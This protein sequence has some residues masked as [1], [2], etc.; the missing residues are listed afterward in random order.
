MTVLSDYIT[1]L[2]NLL[3]DPFNNFYTL[4]NMKAWINT[5]RKR[6]AAEAQAIR[7]LPT[8][9]GT[10]DSIAVDT[11]GSLYTTATV[12]IS[13]PDAFGVGFVTA[14]ATAT[15]LAGAV[16]AI[17]VTNPG[18]GYIATPTVTITGD[19]SGATATAT[20][21]DFLATVESQ[22]VYDFSTA[23]ALLIA[24]NPGI[25][26]IIAV[27]S[28]A[29]SWGAMKP[30]LEYRDWSS[31]Q[32]YLRSYNVGSQNYPTVW[33]QYGRG[34]SGSVYF[35]P[36]P[37]TVAGMDWDCYCDP[38]A[39]TDDDDTE[40]LPYPWTD[41]VQFLAAEYAYRNAQRASDAARMKGEYKRFLRENE[42][43]VQASMV[44]SFY[45]G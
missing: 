30:V 3:N 8:S 32:A 19:G 34:K 17:T 24:A 39:L 33:S 23:N 27:Q 28:I 29:V 35:W 20:L 37:A 45:R 25:E 38:I 16:T 4:P 31:F 6:I 7:A 5:A 9:S 40:A 44:P 13:A 11:G 42:A 41:A 14:T 43:Y 15:L 22:E 21:T 26:S 12:T 18:S 1:E 2:R 10:V 36:I